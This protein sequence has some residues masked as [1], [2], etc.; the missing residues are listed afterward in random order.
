MW[1]LQLPGIY[2]AKKTAFKTSG[3]TTA[4]FVRL[5]QNVRDTIKML[6]RVIQVHRDDIKK[7]T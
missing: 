7:T 5:I 2:A 1:F 4:N 6:L 3:M